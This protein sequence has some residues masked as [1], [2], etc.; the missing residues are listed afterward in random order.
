VYRA[1]R[2]YNLGMRLSW[3][4]LVV[5]MAACGGPQR[6]PSRAESRA[7]AVA[8]APAADGMSADRVARETARIEGSVRALLAAARPLAAEQVIAAERAAL[9]FRELD[10]LWLRLGDEVKE[11]GRAR[12]ARITP[13][14]PAAT[15]Y[16]ARLAAGTCEHFGVASAAPPVAAGPTVTVAVDGI[17]PPDSARLQSEVARWLAASPWHGEIGPAISAKVRGTLEVAIVDETVTMRAKWTEQVPYKVERSRR[18][19]YQEPYKVTESETV[20]VP[21]RTTR[22]EGYS[23]GTMDQPKTCTRT[24]EQTVHR[25]EERQ[26]EVVRTRTR[27]RTERF[28]ETYYRAEPRT[29]D[30]DAVERKGTYAGALALTVVL[31]TAKEPVVVTVNA[32]DRREGLDHDVD[33]PDA[34]VH[35]SKSG[36]MSETEWVAELS[37]RLEAELRPALV[38]RWEAAFCRADTFTAETAARCG[39]GAA[40]PAA[41]LPAL[42][43]A[44]GDD[45]ELVL[46]QLAARR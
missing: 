28:P 34:G 40:L 36:V 35:P 42:R 6:E 43:S 24:V 32:T 12:C 14:D 30:F 10:G 16:L 4:P 21:I 37:R 22:H 5:T 20:Q 33:I 1:E 26:R 46:A 15:P 18:V 39:F 19:A 13:P 27:Y 17:D 2:G 25:D 9:P 41:A 7:P 29:R 3:F 31:G 44:L 11:A 38:A 23:C 8:G 45:A